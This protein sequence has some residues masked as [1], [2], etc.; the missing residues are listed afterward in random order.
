MAKFGVFADEHPQHFTASPLLGAMTG[1]LAA[2]EGDANK[3]ILYLR[4]RQI[5]RRVAMS[6]ASPRRLNSALNP[7]GRGIDKM[8]LSSNLLGRRRWSS[9]VNRPRG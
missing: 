2:F 3:V 8:P 6:K 4:Q 1:P 9:P 7:A 5:E